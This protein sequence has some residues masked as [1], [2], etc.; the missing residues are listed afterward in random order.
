MIVDVNELTI[1]EII[2]SLVII[3]FTSVQ[4]YLHFC[5]SD[6][7]N[8]SLDDV[9][10]PSEEELFSDDI[11]DVPSSEAVGLIPLSTL[12]PH[13]EQ[14]DT[15]M[16]N[17]QQELQSIPLKFRKKFKFS[18]HNAITKKNVVLLCEKYIAKGGFAHVFS[19]SEVLQNTEPTATTSNDS[20][21]KVF[22]V[23]ISFSKNDKEM[24][25]LDA[26]HKAGNSWIQGAIHPNLVT[27][28][29]W[30][31]DELDENGV[32]FLAPG[33]K[34]IAPYGFIVLELGHLGDVLDSY[35]VNAFRP[36]DQE[37]L[38]PK[39][40]SEKFLKR[41]AKDLLHGIYF[42]HSHGII[43]R[44]LKPENLVIDCY[45]HIKVTDWGLILPTASKK[46]RDQENLMTVESINDKG[47]GTNGYRSPEMYFDHQNGMYLVDEKINPN[48]FQDIWSA[49]ATLL[50]IQTACPLEQMYGG[51]NRDGDPRYH[52]INFTEKCVHH[53][54]ENDMNN[55]HVKK[56][57]YNWLK[58]WNSYE[59]GAYKWPISKDMEDFYNQ[60][61]SV[62]FPSKRNKTPFSSNLRKSAKELLQHK[63]LQYG[64]AND[65]EFAEELVNRNVKRVMEG[66]QLAPKHSYLLCLHEEKA[67][68]FACLIGSAYK[69]KYSTNA[70]WKDEYINEFIITL[71][72]KRFLFLAA[73]ATKNRRKYQYTFRNIDEW[74]N[75]CDKSI[76]QSEKYLLACSLKYIGVDDCQ[77]VYK[78]CLPSKK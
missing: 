16:N 18:Y 25:R 33:M 20:L 51:K 73:T 31:T 71:G 29:G 1:I 43:H 42:M 8:A 2:V 60:I 28:V 61:F 75:F 21:G 3:C 65:I 7:S 50:V 30:T 78:H 40:F 27:V 24:E 46:R 67:H 76:N 9:W 32:S 72:F 57:Y 74:L 56:F 15:P 37:E 66:L 48:E 49:G 52:D 11:V 12:K 68:F 22:A 77:W 14:L 63:W 53:E 38:G 64:I 10:K 58:S 34:K 62:Q 5:S 35:M 39:P 69:K 47:L 54:N 36:K 59:T 26:R 6:S 4:I 19:A 17:T 41:I 13:F 45:G 44:D 70:N 23:K 55:N